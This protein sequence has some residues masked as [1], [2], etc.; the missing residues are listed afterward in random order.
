MKLEYRGYKLSISQWAIS[1]GI[2]RQTI[3]MRIRRG[4]SAEDALTLPPM[5]PEQ[6]GRI[7]KLRAGDLTFRGATPK[8]DA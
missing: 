6:S 1:T 2:A 8:R 3:A 5:P 7:G 4:Y